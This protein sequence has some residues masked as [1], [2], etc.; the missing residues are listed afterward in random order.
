DAIANPVQYPQVKTAYYIIQACTTLVGLFV[1]P[2]FTYKAFNSQAKTVFYVS[3][4]ENNIRYY[5]IIILMAFA[6]IIALSPLAEWNANLNLE[7]LLGETGVYLKNLEKKLEEVTLFLTDFSSPIQYVVALFV[8]AV[9]PA[10][11]EE[12]VFRGI[13]QKH[14]IGLSKNAHVGIWLSAILF[15]AFH[16]Q[17]FG[18]VPRMLLGVFFGYIFYWSGN[19]WFAI[20]AHFC[21]NAIALTAIYLAKL[22]WVDADINKTESA[23]WYL[24]LLA[25]LIVVFLLNQFY[26]IHKQK[27]FGSATEIQ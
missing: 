21:N 15:S 25:S 3:E 19:L 17:F 22:K 6:F 4:K 7:P 1:L 11:A 9:L 8:I 26:Q 24:V 20:F 5:V 14:L 18:F 16:M 12:F 2:W 13:V 23:P 10:L 27:N